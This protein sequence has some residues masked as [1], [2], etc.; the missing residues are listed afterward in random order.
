MQEKTFISKLNLF[1]IVF[2]LMIVIGHT[3]MHFEKELLPLWLIHKF[4]MVGV[5]YFFFTS[6][7]SCAYS[8]TRKNSGIGKYCFRKI[9]S[10]ILIVGIC[11]IVTIG[12]EGIYADKFRNIQ[13]N[14]EYINQKINWYIWVQLLF[15]AVFGIIY[16]WIP[17]RRSKVL[18]F[19]LFAIIQMVLAYELHLSHAYCY[20]SMGFPMGIFFHEYYE[21]IRQYRAKKS[22]GVLRYC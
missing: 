5:C 17:D 21:E 6:G 16:K 19:A 2:A 14:F 4:N 1:R 10:L 3:S 7:V 9:L 18:L 20:S 13:Y 15:Y 8:Y 11:I 12:I 22:G